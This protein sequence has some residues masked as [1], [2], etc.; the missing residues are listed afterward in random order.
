MVSTELEELQH[1][2]PAI[3][4]TLAR[5]DRQLEQW[6]RGHVDD[7]WPHLQQAVAEALQSGRDEFRLTQPARSLYRQLV[8]WAHWR[9]LREVKQ[10]EVAAALASLGLVRVRRDFGIE[11]VGSTV[12]A[13]APSTPAT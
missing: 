9:G 12:A 5:L 2:I 8:A 7:R 3:R 10:R 13:P 4:R 6:E 11:W 1:L